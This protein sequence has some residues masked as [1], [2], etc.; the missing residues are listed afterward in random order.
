MGSLYGIFRNNNGKLS[1]HNKIYE[2][3]IYNYMVSKIQT[4]AFFQ[5]YK[6]PA[7]FINKD[8]S[9]D[10]KRVFIKFKEFMK[11]EYSNKR[12]GFLEEDGR[13]FLK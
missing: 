13:L 9:L 3:L 5:D 6:D 4:S 8:G 12:Q 1:I 2:Q 10:I 11:H 7:T